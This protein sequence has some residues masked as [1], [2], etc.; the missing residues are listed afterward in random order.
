MPLRC[1]ASSGTRRVQR[2]LRDGLPF[3]YTEADAR[4]LSHG[5]AGG[6]PEETFPFAIAWD[7]VAI[8]SLSLLHSAPQGNSPRTAAWATTWAGP[9]GAGE[10]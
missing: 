6:G 3:P 4:T 1:P 10:S 2:N 9:I 5:H 7:D 8:G